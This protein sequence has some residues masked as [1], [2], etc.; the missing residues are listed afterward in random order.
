MN[1][2]L[3]ISALLALAACATTEETKVASTPLSWCNP[4]TYP[5]A[6]ASPCAAPVVA[7]PKPAYKPPPAPALS[8]AFDPAPGEFQQAQQVA[9]SSPTPGAVIHYTTDGSTPTA[10]SPV[11]SAPIAVEQSSTIRTLVTAPDVPDSSISEGAYVIAPPPP[12]VEAAAP[13]PAPAPARVV[14]TEKKL[15]LGEKVY[16]DTAKT[17]IKPTSFSLLDDV[18]QAL[19]Q[20]PQVKKVVIEG[21]TDAVGGEAKNLKLSQGRAEAV[22]AYLVKK[23]VE[24]DRLDAKGYGESR[25][26]ADNK[27]AQGRESNRRVEFVIP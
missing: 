2:L 6:C 23:G 11:Y 20:N 17:S 10:A 12:K 25:P 18:A 9:L 7:A 5:S 19:A 13:P 22:R 4:C 14:V 26:I 15:E 21:H 1:K 8:A 3:A 27:T 16:F 24:A